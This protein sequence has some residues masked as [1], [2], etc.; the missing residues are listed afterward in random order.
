MKLIPVETLI[1]STELLWLLEPVGVDK[2]TDAFSP[3][4]GN[5][6]DRNHNDKRVLC[7]PTTKHKASRKRLEGLGVCVCFNLSFQISEGLVVCFVYF[8]YHTWETIISYCLSYYLFIGLFSVVHCW[9]ESL[10]IEIF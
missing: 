10:M 4:N 5:C 9:G 8:S 2:K 1:M 6:L 3:E 7:I